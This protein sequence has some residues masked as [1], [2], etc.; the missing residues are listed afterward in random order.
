MSKDSIK[1][2]GVGFHTWQVKVKGL[3]MRKNLWSVV[4]KD[5]EVD[6]SIRTRGQAS[7]FALKDEKALG[8]ILTSMGDDYLHYLDEPNTA[9]TAWETL[10]RLFGAKS[11]HSKISLKMQL[12]GLVMHEK[13]SLS[14]LVNR[15]MSICSQLTYIESPVEEE[16]KI[17]VLLKALP[18]EYNQIVTVLK[19]K[20][21]IPSLES[22]INSL[23]EEDKKIHKEE[24]A[25]T[26]IGAF[27]VTQ[28]TF[29]KCQH[30][31]KNNHPA[32]KCYKVIACTNCGKK[33]HPPQR[34]F[35]NNKDEDKDKGKGKDV[36][37]SKDHP[38]S[39]VY[40]DSTSAS[41]LDDQSI[42]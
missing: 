20:E 39:F 5:G 30:C 25:A 9:R 24:P 36:N 1:F 19:E 16:D 29:P 12:Y 42:C 27:A 32:S 22:V 17:A 4:T 6:D 41:D 40:D 35:S 2:N 13:E 31:G 34:C 26:I 11:K 23:Q 10:E 14:S 3:L 38:I 28:R 18:K 33:G 15:L 37:N 7:Q 8:I 21:P